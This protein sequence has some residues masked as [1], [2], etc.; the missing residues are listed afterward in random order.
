MRRVRHSQGQRSLSGSLSSFNTAHGP[1]KW[2]QK[3][4]IALK[5][6]YIMFLEIS[7]KN[8]YSTKLFGRGGT[9]TI[10]QH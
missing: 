1:P 4:S 10:Q 8:Y 9:Q 6:E 3:T 7:I 5:T 2:L